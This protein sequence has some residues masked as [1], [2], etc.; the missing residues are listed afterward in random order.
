MGV[1]VLARRRLSS[2]ALAVEV[3]RNWVLAGQ[4][5]PEE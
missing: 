5:P 2:W 3:R 1:A 4:H